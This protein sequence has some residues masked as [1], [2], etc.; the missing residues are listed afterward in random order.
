MLDLRR[1]MVICEFARRGSIAATAVSLGYSPSAVSQ[2]LAALEREAGTAL[3]DRTARSAELTDAGRRLV[4]HAERILSMVEAAESDLSAQV[5]TPSGRVM[6]TAFPTAAVAFAPALA[7]SLRRHTSLTLR[8]RQRRSGLGMREV[9]SGEADIAL[10][11]DWYGRVRER[12]SGTLRVFPLLR[13]PLVLVVPRK[14]RMAD[15][16]VPVDLMALRGESWMATPDGEPSRL[17]VDRLLAD[18]GGAPPVP[19]E[20]EG[21]GTI[22]SLVA[23]GIGI[24]A[25]P[26]LALAAGVRGIVVREFPVEPAEPAEYAGSAAFAGVSEAGEPF[27]AAEAII[28]GPVVAGTPV[29]PA[30]VG[31]EVHAV[32]RVS[33]VHRPSVSVTLRALHVAAR[34]LAAD[35]APLALAD[36]DPQPAPDR[37]GRSS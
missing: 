10:V 29:Y 26:A 5:A 23:K 28:G 2:Q 11:D 16:A 8:M 12:A 15:P 7:R 25:V 19:W 18:V 24:A 31:R 20:F 36:R 3:L 37:Y 9:E 21:L 22:L 30:A 32:A 17:A 33:S 1:L 27:D 4:V 6:I 13:D 35:L 34:L 14:H